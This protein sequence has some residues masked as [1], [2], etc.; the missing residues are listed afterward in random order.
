MMGRQPV[1]HEQLGCTPQDTTDD[2]TRVETRLDEA[3]KAAL[4]RQGARDTDHVLR[5]HPAERHRGMVST[6]LGLA[7][8]SEATRDTAEALD[9]LHLARVLLDA[10]ERRLRANRGAAP[11]TQ[12]AGLDP[13]SALPVRPL[14]TGGLTW[15]EAY[16]L[17][18]KVFPDR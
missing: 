3:A 17:A 7:V 12:I 9:H 14:A 2:A 16:E 13:P 8:S 15:D 1:W 6:L 18:V 4:S 11:P 5:I 10:W